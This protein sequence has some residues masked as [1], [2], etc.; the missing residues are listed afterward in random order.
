MFS[1]KSLMI[2]IHIEQC[3]TLCCIFNNSQTS[4]VT[5]D[6]MYCDHT[7]KINMLPIREI[8]GA[9]GNANCRNLHNGFFSK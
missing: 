5:L 8:L 1:I 9:R 2:K 7:F 3:K 6:A 4:E